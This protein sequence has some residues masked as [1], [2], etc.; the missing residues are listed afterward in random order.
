[1]A[2][3]E[4]K[5]VKHKKITLTVCN[6]LPSKS[7]PAKLKFLEELLQSLDN[8]E[9]SKKRLMVLNS[10]EKGNDSDF[11]ASYTKT[12]TN[13]LFGSFIRLNPD[14]KTTISNEIL[15]KNQVNMEEITF[16]SNE[17]IAGTVK[18]S[19]Y[20]GVS[21]NKIIMSGCHNNVRALEVYINWLLTEIGEFKETYRI[22]KQ[23]KTKEKITID[24]VKSV[25]I[26]DNYLDSFFLN[27]A[28][29]NNVS[30]TFNLK[31]E[32]I[33][34]F[35][36][37]TETK[38]DIDVENII[39]AY[40]TFKLNKK[41]LKK[42][43]AMG[44]LLRIID[45]EDIKMNTRDGKKLTGKDFTVQGIFDIELTD[46]GLFN[47]KDLMSHMEAYLNELKE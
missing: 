23:V 11:I 35:L 43:G 6:V 26:G 16:S 42:E 34:L 20:F 47:E 32:I 27:Q 37:E 14:F 2:E 9:T 36:G 22:Q 21:G 38:E 45:S 12:K 39:S 24:D 41:A 33:K 40:I 19:A 13:F 8:T 31:K 30:K 28:S 29:S 25:R 18:D 15:E 3:K 17:D 44:Q 4:K 10:S 5:S 1:M 7:Q 46:N